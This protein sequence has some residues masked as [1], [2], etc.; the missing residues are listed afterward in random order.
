[1]LNLTRIF[2]LWS[3]LYFE[4]TK[5]SRCEDKWKY[6]SIPTMF[7][8]SLSVI[9]LYRKKY[10]TNAI[11]WLA[12]AIVRKIFALEFI[13]RSTG[14]VEERRANKIR[15]KQLAPRRNGFIWAF[16]LHFGVVTPLPLFISTCNADTWKCIRAIPALA[17][18]TMFPA[19]R[20]WKWWRRRLLHL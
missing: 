16:N 7:A 13:T 4:E 1:V 11:D 9:V 10:R 17:S 20:L 2:Q 12:L 15:V 6:L 14:G 19:I 3:W 5:I 18:P 8:K